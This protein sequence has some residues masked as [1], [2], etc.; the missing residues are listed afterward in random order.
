M[1]MMGVIAI[2]LYVVMGFVIISSVKMQIPAQTIVKMMVYSV[3]MK[4][5][6][7]IAQEMAIAVQKV[8]LVMALK[9]VKI[10]PMAVI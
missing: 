10:K 1:I 3:N 6:L 2:L 8:G 4:D 5:F 9:I 7:M